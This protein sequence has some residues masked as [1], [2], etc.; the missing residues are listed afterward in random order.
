MLRHGS[1]YGSDD[2]ASGLVGLA[3]VLTI[4]ALYVAVRVIIYI[5]QTFL[6]YPRAKGLWYSLGLAVVLGLL[7]W[8]LL[9]FFYID[10]NIAGYL[11]LFALLQLLFVCVV[12]RRKYA[13]TFMRE[14]F[15]IV[16]EVLHR[17]WLADE[18]TPLAA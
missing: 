14:D 5:I 8:V 18:N 3:I 12:V 1:S 16:D 10:P 11:G 17:S 2:W 9:A 13:Q 6:H 4:I 15:N 7:S